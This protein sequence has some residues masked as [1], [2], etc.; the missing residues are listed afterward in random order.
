M[1]APK[2]AQPCLREVFPPAEHSRHGGQSSHSR[3][4]AGLDAPAQVTCPNCHNK[5]GHDGGVRALRDA[6]NAAALH[7]DSVMRV[8]NG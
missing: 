7:T 8:L 4:V 1:P 6:G 2:N 3:S 5:A